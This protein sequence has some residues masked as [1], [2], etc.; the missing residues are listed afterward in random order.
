MSKII[1]VV[2]A[3]G[4]QGGSVVNAFL[5]KGEWKVRG[6]SRN[7]NSE[8]AKLL[9]A[10]GVEMVTADVNDEASL[11]RAFEGVTAIFAMTDFVEPFTKLDI[12]TVMA[13]E[14][15]QGVNMAKAA[16]Q[17]PTL[18]HYIWSTLPNID[19]V[20]GGKFVVPH[21]DAKAKVDDFIKSKP[22]LLAKTTFLWIT[23]Y[24]TNFFFPPFTPYHLK[25]IGT[26][27]YIQ[28]VSRS[29]LFCAAGDVSVNVGVFVKGIL[30]NP[31]KTLS[32]YVI[33]QVEEM[34][35]EEYILLWGK[36]TGK[37]VKYVQIPFEE[38]DK[39]FP[40]WGAEMGVMLLFWE[41]AGEKSWSGEPDILTGAD[42]GVEGELVSS[43]KAFATTDWSAFD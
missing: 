22:E 18:K 24:S 41:W 27:V 28:P 12:D 43:E 9:A 33:M 26:Y 10:K 20:S 1:A 21:C 36:V 6:L 14:Y 13:L 15:N 30:S 19:K 34:T 32:K 29:T 8:K 42:L 2:G 17:T 35:S 40:K 31:S 3:T 38:Y 4:A 37:N 39:L 5:N 16:L 25:S 11:V 7:A 23:F